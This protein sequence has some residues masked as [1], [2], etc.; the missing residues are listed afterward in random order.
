MDDNKYKGTF[1][2]TI[3]IGGHS[4]IVGG[5]ISMFRKLKI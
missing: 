4:Y 1:L 3:N 5:A 2:F